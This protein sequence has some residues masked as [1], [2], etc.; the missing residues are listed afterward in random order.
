MRLAIAAL[1]STTGRYS[2]RIEE[3]LVLVVPK[4][5][6]QKETMFTRKDIFKLEYCRLGQSLNMYN[7]V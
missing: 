1:P 5:Y 6:Y 2:L 7:K 3:Y 4:V